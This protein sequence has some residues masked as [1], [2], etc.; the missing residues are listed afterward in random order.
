MR[1]LLL[2][3]LF[4]PF[5]G[6][7]QQFRWTGDN[8]Y[9]SVESGEIVEYTLPQLTKTVVA[10][11]ADLTPSAKAPLGVKNFVMSPDQSRIL[12]FANT[13]K[14][15]RLE[16]RGDYWILDLSSKQLK[17]LGNGLPAASLMFAK[18]SPDNSKVAYVSEYNVFTEDL[19]TGKITKHTADG[20]RKLING[21]FDWAYEEE[22]S[23]RDGILWSPDSRQLAFWQVDATK[24]RDFYMINNTDSV[25][26]RVVPVEYPTAGQTPSPVRIG[27]VDVTTGSTKWVPTPG[28]PKQH[29]LPRIEW[30]SATELFMQQLNRKQNESRILSYNT[31]DNSVKEI[32]VDKD[33][34]WIDI[35]TPWENVYAL[36]FR[37]KINWI[38]GGKEFIWF[39]E[40]DGWRH[41]YRIAKDGTAK[42]ITN[43][44]YDVLDIRLIDEKGKYLYFLASPTNATQKYLFRCKLDGSGKAER[45]TPADQAG[46]HNYLLAPGGKFAYQTFSN[47]STKPRH[48]WVSLPQHKSLTSAANTASV[49][50]KK[51]EFFKVKTS[52]GVEMDGWMVK[53]ARFDSTKKYPVLFYVYT[54]PWG[55]N[56]KDQYGAAENF[57]FDGDL[58]DEGY[59]YIS[60]DNRGTP[61][62]K[63]RAWR[64][65]V[66]RKI[67][68]L[69]IQDQA[70]AAREI[71]RWKFVD[72]ER[73]A[74][75]GWS[76]GGAATLNLMFQYP[77][78]YKTGIAVAAV[79]NQ[80]TYDNI[81]QER[82]MGLPQENMEDFVK[83]SPLTYAKNLKGNLLYVHGT[84]DDNVHYANGEMLIN[85]LVKHGKQFQLMIYP[86]RTHG[87]SEGEGTT[88]HLS[89]LY[90]DY[91]RKY[92]PPGPK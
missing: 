51:V 25:Y 88:E 61:A 27:I 47:V 10:T 75:W 31:T 67:G 87:I 77:D 7:S 26:S 41:V 35:Y 15:W 44:D 11:I 17:K 34:A 82:F 54:E 19:A 80:L 5:I 56:V 86:N 12:I 16:T 40:R 14:V 29:Y 83:G 90:S 32:F 39:S 49:E 20:T 8:K 55:A 9:L 21:T 42:L 2:I 6:V 81:Y 13:K 60:V 4:I 66:Y 50:S 68:L 65:S 69:N 79:T 72:P 43:G 70:D 30:N 58:A 62:P 76:G 91:L 84:G 24:I 28:D 38:N 64:K 3:L 48:G 1:R 23:C 74:V 45:L 57:L 71:L 36:D 73:V 63:G 59:I 46:T 52:G 33:E 85:E 18:F 78:I 37:H 89:K 22:F 53:P 92:C